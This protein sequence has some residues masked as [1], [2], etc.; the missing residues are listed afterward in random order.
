MKIKIEFA[1]TAIFISIFLVSL[2]ISPFVAGQ[3]QEG[4]TVG[5]VLKYV[6]L[7]KTVDLLFGLSP[8]QR[9]EVGIAWLALFIMLGF[10]FSDIIELFT[11]FSR[12]TAYILGFGLSL[13]TAMARATFKLSLLLFSI[14]GGVGVVSVFISIIVAFGIFALLHIASW[15]IV[16]WLYRKRLQQEAQR[17]G[18]EAGAGM[19]AF[20]EALRVAAGAPY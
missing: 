15:K 9:I 19:E 16:R 1:L 6:K 20:R 4:V 18:A 14:A 3:T 12:R 8:N 17:I 10:A 11:A 7:N 5:D 13:I 2:F